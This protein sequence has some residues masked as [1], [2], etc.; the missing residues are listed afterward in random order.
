MSQPAAPDALPPTLAEIVD[1]FT[2]LTERDRLQLLL[3]FA[4]S[5]PPL[6]LRGRAAMLA[7]INRQVRARRVPA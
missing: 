1:E 6:R 7:R 5:L 3:E 2:V 4:H